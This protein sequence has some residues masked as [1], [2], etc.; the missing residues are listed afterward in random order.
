MEHLYFDQ[1]GIIFDYLSQFDIIRFQIVSKHM[2]TAVRKYIDTT[3]FMRI[4]NRNDLYMAFKFK[5]AIS[6]DKMHIMTYHNLQ[7]S[8]YITLVQYNISLSSNW[9]AIRCGAFASGDPKWVKSFL[10]DMLKDK[11]FSLNRDESFI[12][13]IIANGHFF[14]FIRYIQYK[15]YVKGTTT[16]ENCLKN[17]LLDAIRFNK[18]DIILYLIEYEDIKSLYRQ[19]VYEISWTVILDRLEIFK[20]L[21]EYFISDNNKYKPAIFEANKIFRTP[22]GGFSFSDDTINL[23]QCFTSACANKHNHF[24][25]YLISLMSDPD[26]ICKCCQISMN[27]HHYYN[28][29]S[30]LL[31]Y[32]KIDRI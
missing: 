9:N 17:I 18:K 19:I 5:A 32:N 23:K 24:F 8:Q 1:L 11:S 29:S 13:A 2:Q 6:I 16:Y 14:K 31:S 30:S 12:R 20:L 25:E 4:S 27:E 3:Q 22:R 15:P 21:V 10:T 28:R 26:D 7:M